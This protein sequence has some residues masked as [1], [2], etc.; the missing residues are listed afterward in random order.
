MGRKCGKL[1]EQQR[2]TELAH[3]A[4]SVALQANLNFASLVGQGAD[5]KSMKNKMEPTNPNASTIEKL[6]CPKDTLVGH[7]CGTLCRTLL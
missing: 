6:I 3:A 4:D 1:L 2:E 5:G 7:S